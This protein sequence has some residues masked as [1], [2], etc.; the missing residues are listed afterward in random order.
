MDLGIGS[1]SKEGK[2]V[3]RLVLNVCGMP[4]TGDVNNTVFGLQEP[5]LEGNLINH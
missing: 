3:Y 2:A 5:G 1:P 4:L